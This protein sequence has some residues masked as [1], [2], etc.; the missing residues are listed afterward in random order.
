MSKLEEL[1]KFL[2]ENKSDKDVQDYLAEMKK[3]TK[4]SVKEFLDSDEGKKFHQPILDAY[5]TKSLKTWQENNL[6]KIKSEAI[7]SSKN[8]TPE[9][10][11]IRELSENLSVEK[12]ARQKESIKNKAIQALTS[13]SLPL[14]LADFLETA[15]TDDELNSKIEKI[16]GVFKNYSD[17][18]N[19]DIQSANGRKPHIPGKTALTKEILK[20][21]APEQVMQL[22]EEEINAVLMQG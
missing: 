3:A 8:E 20:T 4:E 17:K 11:A 2:E 6:E 9:Q 1:K 10:K 12:R 21:L 15:E 5:H 7:A 16:S 22:P 19:A 18:L 13:K 14:D